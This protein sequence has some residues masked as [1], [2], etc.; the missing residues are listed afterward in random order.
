MQ[1]ETKK[2]ITSLD[3]Q[4]TKADADAERTAGEVKSLEEEIEK[5]EGQLA[6]LEGGKVRWVI[7]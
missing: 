5:Q 3:G 6:A 7:D 2:R 4:L 1:E